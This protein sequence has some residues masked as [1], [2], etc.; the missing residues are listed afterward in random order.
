MNAIR[1]QT[2]KNDGTQER[3][4][5][6]FGTSQRTRGITMCRLQEQGQRSEQNRADPSISKTKRL[7]FPDNGRYLMRI[8]R[9]RKALNAQLKNPKM[10]EERLV[11][12][13]CMSAR[14][15][16]SDRNQ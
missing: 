4:E 3:N 2:G 10:C 12:L 1:R 13:R 9:L 11:M 14:I 15:A 6:E 7:R 8:R 16:P 5:P